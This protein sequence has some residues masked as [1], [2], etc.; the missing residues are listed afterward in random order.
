[1]K[2]V[3]YIVLKD[4]RDRFNN[5]RHCKPGEEHVPPNEE[6]AKQLVDLGFI[7]PVEDRK[8][9]GDEDKKKTSGSK[10]GSKGKSKSDKKEQPADEL[11]GGGD[12]GEQQTDESSEVK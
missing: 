3:K 11:K 12:D 10:G 1:M 8:P 6:R 7:S 2:H 5:M 4:F 9:K